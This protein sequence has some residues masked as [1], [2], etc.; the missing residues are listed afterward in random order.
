[1][2]NEQI[3]NTFVPKVTGFNLTTSGPFLLDTGPG[4]LMV[5]GLRYTVGGTSYTYTPSKD[6]YDDLIAN[7][8]VLD[9]GDGATTHYSGYLN[10]FLSQ[11]TGHIINGTVRITDGSLQT[12]DTSTDNLSP[13]APEYTPAYVETGIFSGDASGTINYF[14]GEYIIN[15]VSPPAMG[16]AIRAFALNISHT[17]VA[18]GAVQPP[19]PNQTSVRLQKIVTSATGIASTENLALSDWSEP[20]FVAGRNL[21]SRELNE[22]VSAL[23][24]KIEGIGNTIFKDGDIVS[25]CQ[26]TISDD[27]SIDP[28][29]GVSSYSAEIS[30]GSIYFRGAVHAVKGAIV[31]ITKE[32]KDT[33]GLKLVDSFLTEVDDPFLKDPATGFDGTGLP[34]AWRSMVKFIWASNDA[35]AQTVFNLQY[36]TL[37]VSNPP[38]IYS[39]INNALA[40]RT[41]DESGDYKVNG[42]IGSISERLV[43]SIDIEGKTAQ[44]IDDRNWDL[45]VAGGTA[46][47]TGYAVQKNATTVLPYKRAT[48]TGQGNY[49]FIYKTNDLLDI[50]A[51]SAPYTELY[52]P[53]QQPLASVESVIGVA[54]TPRMR[55]IVTAGTQNLPL[56][57]T[58]L[59]NGVQ[60]SLFSSI[61]NLNIW[62]R[63]TLYTDATALDGSNGNIEL[64]T[65]PVSGDT[66][67]WGPNQPIPG[68]II[69]GFWNYNTDNG[70][71][72]LAK[73]TRLLTTYSAASKPWQVLTISNS[74]PDLTYPDSPKKTPQFNL[75]KNDIVNIARSTDTQ[76]AVHVTN[77]TDESSPYHKVYIPGVDYTIYTGQYKSNIEFP[78]ADPWD[79]YNEYNNLFY[80]YSD[81]VAICNDTATTTFNFTL[82]RPKIVHNGL[83]INIQNPD[84]STT[85]NITLTDD[86]MGI[87]RSSP[88][89]AANGSINYDTGEV[90]ITFT[91]APT[92]DKRIIATYFHGD[93]IGKGR[94]NILRTSSLYSSVQ[95]TTPVKIRVSYKY[96]DHTKALWDTNYTDSGEGDFLGPDSYLE[97]SSGTGYLS[98]TRSP[99]KLYRVPHEL[100]GYANKSSIDFRPAGV[101]IGGANRKL[102]ITSNWSEGKR[103][104]DL[105]EQK[106]DSGY[107]IKTR[108]TSYLSRFDLVTLGSNGDINIV[109]GQDNGSTQVPM[110]YDGD[111]PILSIYQEPFTVAPIITHLSTTRS[112]MKDISL[113]KERVSNV[114]VEVATTALE[115]SALSSASTFLVR[116]IWTDNFTNFQGQDLN[117]KGIVDIEDP[118]SWL[119]GADP[120]VTANKRL[121]FLGDIVKPA[122]GPHKLYLNEDY[123]LKCVRSGSSVKVNNIEVFTTF[124]KSLSSSRIWLEGYSAAV[125]GQEFTPDTSATTAALWVTINKPRPDIWDGGAFKSGTNA[126]QSR[127][128]EQGAIVRS[129]NTNVPVAFKC[130][131]AGTPNA[132]TEPSAWTSTSGSV[133]R[134][135]EV[136]VD[137]GVTWE[138]IRLY[139]K[140]IDMKDDHAAIDFRSKSLRLKEILTRNLVP[141]SVKLKQSNTSGLLVYNQL[142]ILGNANS[143][144]SLGTAINQT[145]ATGSVS[146]NPNSYTRSVSL[147]PASEPYIEQ[148]STGQMSNIFPGSTRSNTTSG[149]SRTRYMGENSTIDGNAETEGLLYIEPLPPTAQI[150]SIIGYDDIFH[151]GVH[152]NALNSGVSLNANEATIVDE[153][154][155]KVV[156]AMAGRHTNLAGSGFVPQDTNMLQTPDAVVVGG[157]LVNTQA[158]SYARSTTIQITG[159]LWEI[160]VP[161]SC[162]LNGT[163][164]NIDAVSTKDGNPTNTVNGTPN[165]GR[166][167]VLPSSVNDGTYGSFLGS[168][169]IPHYSDKKIKSGMVEVKLTAGGVDKITSYVSQGTLPQTTRRYVTQTS[170][171]NEIT[172]EISPIA[173]TFSLNAGHG[174][175]WLTGVGLFF[176]KKDASKSVQIEIRNVINGYPGQM[177]LGKG[178]ASPTA[179]KG[180]YTKNGFLT[181]KIE[182]RIDRPLSTPT[183]VMLEHPVLI[184]PDTEYAIALLT[185]SSEYSLWAAKIGDRDLFSNNIITSQPAIGSLFTSTNG[186]TWTSDQLKDLS[187]ILYSENT[188]SDSQQAKSA[189]VQIGADYAIRGNKIKLN[190]TDWRPSYLPAYSD[191]GI[192]WDISFNS[193]SIRTDWLPIQPKNFIR[194]DNIVESASLRVTLTAGKVT[195]NTWLSPSFNPEHLALY[196]YANTGKNLDILDCKIYGWGD[197]TST[198]YPPNKGGTYGLYISKNTI[199]LNGPFD[200][201]RMVTD[202]YKPI[203]T[204]KHFVKR[205]TI[206]EYSYSVDNGISWNQFANSSAQS[207]NEQ[208][209]YSEVPLGGFV[210]EVTRTAKFNRLLQP[211]NH[212]I[213]TK[214]ATTSTDPN[215]LVDS[216]KYFIKYTF[217]TQYGESIAADVYDS[218]SPNATAITLTGAQNTISFT[219]PTTSYFPENSAYNNGLPVKLSTLGVNV[220]LA[221]KPSTSTDIPSASEYMLNAAVVTLTAGGTVTVLLDKKRMP[222]KSAPTYDNSRPSQFRVMIKLA[223]PATARL[224]D[225]PTAV[226]TVALV[227]TGGSLATNKKYEITYTWVSVKDRDP[228]GN[229]VDG[230]LATLLD[231]DDIS[232]GYIDNIY[233]TQHYLPLSGI[234]PDVTTST[235]TSRV[236]INKLPKE[237]WPNWAVGAVFYIKDVTVGVTNSS[238]RMADITVSRG[239]VAAVVTTHVLPTD[240]GDYYYIDTYPNTAPFFAP[241]AQNET[242]GLC[243][244]SPQVSA[245]RVIAHLDN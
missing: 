52:Y 240:T 141:L 114:E 204:D 172:G 185:N 11:N 159:D 45:E 127:N 203:I 109:Y 79:I 207:V 245:L 154:G 131:V 155:V 130:L 13:T 227:T 118:P 29:R 143:S 48:G 86:G 64:D 224:I 215:A 67:V 65:Q 55:I 181:N 236:R 103:L 186:K 22:I 56:T 68:T 35:N 89:G 66:I 177:V 59:S 7:N 166:A 53:K 129:S 37:L 230:T 162:Y 212:S 167:T 200:R 73:G 163:Q 157:M 112:T 5:A 137:S 111:M 102:A 120:T 229:G 50:N 25:G 27:L 199:L 195:G 149:L 126:A 232:A 100:L 221:S 74:S 132:T 20:V 165:N 107:G 206:I 134:I 191:S 10:A 4:S 16:A 238:L 6:T 190:V 150:S 213:V 214:S 23:N 135:G 83:Y 220:Y 39:N 160:G 119:D 115:N 15:F 47:V 152:V 95:S 226:P 170:T 171:P 225:N 1:M 19:M 14:N 90:S 142:A 96:W 153:S 178:I 188:L 180:P 99:G 233:E 208:L 60:G 237:V 76:E 202:E 184:T 31:Y 75:G 218:V 9:I 223:A 70:A 28:V 187:F 211:S 234:L 78:A 147:N 71:L 108:V 94:I 161:I 122:V 139:N 244:A 84:Y 222:Q 182:A 174:A 97:E 43:E 93:G 63:I 128:Y 21:Q 40:R 49:D 17:P 125:T 46:Y 3:I 38:T 30:D 34:G 41:Y 179:D 58:V 196:A 205:G 176:A 105:G 198:E 33:I 242:P 189:S 183:R 42:Y 18:N 194:V 85:G 145:K 235:A 123:Y 138:A 217:E 82:L 136:F 98:F 101:V 80:I 168:I 121:Y 51:D 91:T 12:S 209:T 32:D 36:G 88:P 110:S 228:D 61:P 54:R 173:Q 116:G 124:I 231:K 77:D 87:I 133:I 92:A 2:A 151:T 148:Y 243:P 24:N 72:P 175:F 69:F 104:D 8:Q 164:V 158:N 241:P 216:N 57:S 106:L 192:K 81:L 197:P 239:G 26:V 169:Q 146:A 156:T 113:L 140:I 210:S 144:T 201:I 62:N 193:G 117:F 44:H 219:L